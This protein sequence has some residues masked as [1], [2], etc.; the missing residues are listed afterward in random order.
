MHR[1]WVTRFCRSWLSPG[2]MI[3]ISHRRNPKWDNRVVKRYKEKKKKAWAL[4]IS[5]VIISLRKTRSISND[6]SDTFL[7]TN[8]VHLVYTRTAYRSAKNLEKS[9]VYFKPAMESPLFFCPQEHQVG[10]TEPAAAVR[11]M[12]RILPPV[13]EV[14]S[15]NAAYA[16]MKTGRLEERYRHQRGRIKPFR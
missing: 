10:G 13:R 16:W 11:R 3:R 6:E 12:T 4:D 8:E 5:F 14:G 9:S 2:K 1:R 7:F 15:V